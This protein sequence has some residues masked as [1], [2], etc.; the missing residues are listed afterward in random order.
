MRILITGFAPRD[1]SPKPGRRKMSMGWMLSELLQAQGHHVVHGGWWHDSPECDIAL[2]GINSPIA[3]GS[4]YTYG[5][6]AAL[7]HYAALDRAVLFIDDPDLHKIKNGFTTLH[8]NPRNLTNQFWV[9]RP[10]YRD[11]QRSA[12]L[13][14]EMQAAVSRVVDPSWS[15]TVLVPLHADGSRA[16][17]VSYLGAWKWR[18]VPVDFTSL[19]LDTSAE[20]RAA[21]PTRNFFI[22]EGPENDPWCWLVHTTAPIIPKKYQSQDDRRDDYRQATGVIEVP[23]STRIRGWWTPVKGT[24]AAMGRFYATRWQDFHD[25]PNPYRVLPSTFEDMLP[26]QRR[27]LI[28]RQYDELQDMLFP[29]LSLLGTVEGVLQSHV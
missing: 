20:N 5:G 14:A 13:Q 19:M 18:V 27:R 25:P 6:L 7:G 29:Y 2:I 16:D 3:P 1:A 21:S 26:S 12:S 10:N 8:G 9:S 15:P 17:V 4:S 23:P 28:N 24:A 11:V 22:Q